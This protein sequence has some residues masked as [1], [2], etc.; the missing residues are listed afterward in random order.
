MNVIKFFVICIVCLVVNI[1]Y[2]QQTEIKSIGLV[3]DE[4][5]YATSPSVKTGGQLNIVDFL[6][7]VH[8]CATISGYAKI[9]DDPNFVDGIN[10][11]TVYAYAITVSPGVVKGLE[12]E[13][14]P[15]KIAVKKIGRSIK[16]TVDGV[17]VILSSCT[18]AEGVHYFTRRKSDG[19]VI[20]DI[21][22]YLGVDLEP[23]C[24]DK[25]F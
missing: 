16:A 23:N 9:S 21:Y 25:F 18:S 5:F 8:C 11:Q 13:G 22:K 12:G 7:N 3:S 4:Y 2:A 24:K 14:I 10:D 1:G 6:G 17:Q 19:K 15:K 20:V